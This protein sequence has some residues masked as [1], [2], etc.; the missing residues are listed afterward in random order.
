MDPALKVIAVLCLVLSAACSVAAQVDG[1]LVAKR[2]VYSPIGPGL[3][4]VRHGADGKFYV[5]AS[6][7]PGLIVFSGE[8]KKLL[9]M[10]ESSGLQPAALEELSKSGEVLTQFGEDCDVDADGNIYIADRGANAVQVYARE[11]RHL[12]TIPVNA[13]VSVAALPDGEV[14]VATF[15]DPSLV[16]VFDKNGRRVREFGDMDTLTERRELN[17]FLNIGELATDDHAHLYYGYNYFPEPTV[18][19]F[20]RFGYAGQEVRY[21]AIDAMP[22]A[23][24]LRR[25][26]EKQEKRGDPPTFKRILTAIGVDRES[27]EVWM[28]M[29]DTLLRFDKDGNRRA[30]YLIY[31]P[32][33]ARLEANVILVLKDRLIIGGDPIGIYEFDRPSSR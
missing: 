26:I 3:K 27:G 15:R 22:E 18:K 31:T 30:T 21:T 4:A 20:D 19:Q 13:P 5:L 12:K 33:N 1:E 2:R 29:G 14:A 16:V 11:G 23:Q 28:A 10:K 25:E 8:G 32:D 6:P 24:A 17:R 9:A 7:N